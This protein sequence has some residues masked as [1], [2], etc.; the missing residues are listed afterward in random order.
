MLSRN[1]LE[2]LDRDCLKPTVLTLAMLSPIEPIDWLC[3]SKPLKPTF[4]ELK[5]PMPVPPAVD[6]E[7]SPLFLSLSLSL[8]LPDLDDRTESDLRIRT[9]L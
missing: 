8:T 7:T 1:M 9:V 6:V 4:I 5:M 2:K 3:E